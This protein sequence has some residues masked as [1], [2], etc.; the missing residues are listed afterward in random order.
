M[1][2]FSVI[3]AMVLILSEGPAEKGFSEE[4]FLNPKEDVLSILGVL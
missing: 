1:F 4:R 3:K 2:K